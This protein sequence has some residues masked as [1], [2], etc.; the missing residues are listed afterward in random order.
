MKTF[1]LQPQKILLSTKVVKSVPEIINSLL[2]P[3]LS[4]NPWYTRYDS[5]HFSIARMERK[6]SVKIPSNLSH[7]LPN[8]FHRVRIKEFFSPNVKSRQIDYFYYFRN[9]IRSTLWNYHFWIW[10]KL[11]MG[12]S[13]NDVTIFWNALYPNNPKERNSCEYSGSV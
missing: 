6:W 5:N 11:E 2:L 9:G 1:L 7:H 13:I 10:K 12:S 8:T 3:R 4:L